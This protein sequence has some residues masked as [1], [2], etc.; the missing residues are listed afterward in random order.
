MESQH[1]SMVKFFIRR[2]HLAQ[3]IVLFLD[4]ILL[5]N[6]HG[7][8]QFRI[9]GDRT[10]PFQSFLGF[11]FFK[12]WCSCFECFDQELLLRIILGNIGGFKLF[13]FDYLLWLVGGSWIAN[14][15]VFRLFELIPLTV[16]C[17]LQRTNRLLLY[18]RQLVIRFVF[19]HFRMLVHKQST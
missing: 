15:E 6:E 12:C 11:V 14:V 13:W 17:L 10:K 19:Y 8:E 9:M 1:V 18:R 4:Y 3:R 5:Q 2:F 16:V 7:M